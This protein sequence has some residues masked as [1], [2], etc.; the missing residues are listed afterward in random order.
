MFDDIPVYY[1]SLKAHRYQNYLSIDNLGQVFQ[2]ENGTFPTCATI[3]KLRE[4]A[5]RYRMEATAFKNP[6]REFL[7]RT[8]QL[9][10]IVN[11]KID[12]YNDKLAEKH[13]GLFGWF[14]SF[15]T[16]KLDSIPDING[17]ALSLYTKEKNL[18]KEMEKLF[19]EELH[20]TLREHNYGRGSF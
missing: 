6:P 5:F 15:F 13:K 4:A 19:P 9:I 1:D 16:K 10:N 12:R 18:D 17:F 7:W 11:Y 14:F 8:V 3:P 2:R 20:S